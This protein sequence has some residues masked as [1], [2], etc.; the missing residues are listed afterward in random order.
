M[1]SETYF[2]SF[3]NLFGYLDAAP[4]S[5][6]INAGESILNA[7]HLITCGILAKTATSI[8]MFALCLKTSALLEKPHEIKGTF[9][10]NKDEIMVEEFTCTCKAGLS[11]RCKHV[12]AVLILCSR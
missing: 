3:K 2:L 1:D 6:C 7:G 9:K 5:R 8:T 12:A 4:T 11:K 10:F